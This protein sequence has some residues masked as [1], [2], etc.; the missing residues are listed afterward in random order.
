VIRLEEIKKADNLKENKG[1]FNTLSDQEIIERIKEILKD[2]NVSFKEK[3]K[4]IKEAE[5]TLKYRLECDSAQ[6]EF[7][8]DEPAGQSVQRVFSLIGELE[9]IE[10]K[11][12]SN[13]KKQII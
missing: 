9:K 13:L 6:E 10:K 5:E 2:K 12:K 3:D 4:K 11:F 8:R 1:D 7:F